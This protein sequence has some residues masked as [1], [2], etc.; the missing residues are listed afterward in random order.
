MQEG[1]S[2]LSAKDLDD[3]LGSN[4]ARWAE[5]AIIDAGL[6]NN[7]EPPY[8]PSEDRSNLAMEYNELIRRSELNILPLVVDAM[9][10]RLKVVGFRNKPSS[11]KS[12]KTVWGW[13]QKSHLDQR[14]VLVHRDAAALRDGFVLVIPGGTDNVPTF[15]PESP[16]TMAVE[17]DPY[18]PMRI[19]RAAKQAGD[20]AWEY[21]E[22]AIITY[23]L[24]GG[25]GGRWK[26]VDFLE[27]AA[28]ECPVVRFP[29]QLDSLGRSMSE[30]E[31]V[32]PVQRRIHQSIMDRLLLQRSQA[33]RQRW[34]S[35][36]VVDRDEDG[37][38]LNPFKVGADRLLVGD[39]P[40]VKFGEFQQADLTG[41][42]RA[43]DDDI[44]A[45]AL[46]TRTPPHYLPGSSISNISAEALTALE[47]ALEARVAER[48]ML[49]GE[50][51][52]TAMRIGGAMV[53]RVIDDSAEV[54]WADL[55]LRSDA[56]RVD[57]A[58][59]LSSIGVPLEFLLERLSLSPQEIERILAAAA[60]QAAAEAKA[61]AAAFGVDGLESDQPVMGGQGG[62]SNADPKQG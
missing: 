8:I 30:V 46:I 52:E 16:L 57:A 51:W 23:E 53:G 19:I 47:A 36:I 10:D 15:Q 18:N 39:N 29:N 3:L 13:W 27:H 12:D 60:K 2:A 5:L 42:L 49:W 37:K 41:L 45:V 61:Q 21:T 48:K 26:E 28:G 31:P 58:T 62:D 4:R 20:R 6:R 34:V 7:W 11:S 25:P 14:Q 59:K 24:N 44:R 22:D 35:G 32:L 55:E 40:D 50:S 38:P 1:G 9:V 17:Q 43:V 56:Q 54:I 33:W